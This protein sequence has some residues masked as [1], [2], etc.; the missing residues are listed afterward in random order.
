[1]TSVLDALADKITGQLAFIYDSD[2][3][4]HRALARELIDLMQISVS[5]ESPKPYQNHWS[6]QDTVMI[7]YADSIIDE[8]QLPLQTLRSF[9]NQHIGTTINGVHI[10]PFFPYSSDD[11]F[12]VIDYSSVNEAHGQSHCQR[13]SLNG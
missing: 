12:A 5:V 2:E 3:V 1:M 4:D 13:T 6:E 8:Q 7:T 9:I 11:G 10:L